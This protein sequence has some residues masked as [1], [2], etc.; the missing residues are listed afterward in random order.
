MTNRSASIT[1]ALDIFDVPWARSMNVMGTSVIVAPA[2]R[3]R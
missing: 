3:A 2:L 1:I